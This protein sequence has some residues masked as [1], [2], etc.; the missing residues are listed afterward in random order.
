MKRTGKIKFLKVH[1][2]FKFT[3][4]KKEKKKTKKKKNSK[5]L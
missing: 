2:Q 5:V 3:F 4:K 1:S